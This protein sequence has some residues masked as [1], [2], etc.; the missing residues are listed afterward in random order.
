[1]LRGPDLLL[2]SPHWKGDLLL[3]WQELQAPISKLSSVRRML[4]IDTKNHVRLGRVQHHGKI[5]HRLPP[6]LIFRSHPFV[7]SVVA[8]TQGET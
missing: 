6:M 5:Q 4:S 8:W 1:M 2:C 3:E 7:L